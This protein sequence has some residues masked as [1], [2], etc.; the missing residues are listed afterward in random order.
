MAYIEHFV[1]F[2]KNFQKLIFLAFITYNIK[3]QHIIG[4][5]QNLNADKQIHYLISILLV[6]KEREGERESM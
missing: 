3:L 5:K 4:T 6:Y 1:N 2:L